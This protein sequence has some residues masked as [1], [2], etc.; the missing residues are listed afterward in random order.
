MMIDAYSHA[1]PSSYIDTMRKLGIQD[2][3]F[4]P[5]HLSNM[6]ERREFLSRFPGL[7]NVVA[8]MELFLSYDKEPDTL[9]RMS[10]IFNEG[11]AELAEQNADI[12]AA[13][14]ATV[15]IHSV[16]SALREAEYAVKKLGLKGIML[17][18]SFF[19]KD[20]ASPEFRPLLQLMA[21]LDRPIW[22]HPNPSICG[23]PFNP[24]GGG[25]EMLSDTADVMLHLACCG[26]FE[27]C[28]NL[29]I[30]CHH[31]GTYIPLFHTRLKSQYFYDV[32]DVSLKYAPDYVEPDHT[33][34][35]RNYENLK[36]FYVDT[37]YYNL[38]APQ[39][40]TSLD[41]FGSDHVLFGTDF[42]LP[43]DAEVAPNIESIRALHLSE[44]EEEKVFHGNI[45]RLLG[46]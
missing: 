28:P 37:A 40:R 10:R 35:L 25:W 23:R 2:H 43:T 1:A 11:M 31:G 3:P 7:K 9:D 12:I 13:A 26:I 32:G 42:P 5:H 17:P 24:K 8:P 20:P 45:E 16:D 29:K 15:P 14:V 6:D 18:C 27:E 34:Q 33:E 4:I 38:C 36:R 22:L 41:F 44:E 39:I 46:L 19:G 21:E 30:V